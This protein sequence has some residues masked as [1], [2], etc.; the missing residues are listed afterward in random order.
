MLSPMTD[1]QAVNRMLKSIG[2]APVNTLEVSGIGDV[3]KARQE[4]EEV[5]RDVQTI[6][7]SWNTDDSYTL[8]PDTDGAIRLPNGALD[9]D[10]TE[11]TQ[12]IVVREHPSGGL[13]LY[14]A[15]NTTFTFTASVTVRVIWGF[16]FNSLPAAA[17][18]YIATAAARRF[19]AQV[20]SSTILDRF[21]ETD[22]QRAWVLLQ[23][24]ERATRD[25]NLFR[26]NS[27]VNKFG[28]RRRF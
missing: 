26:A 13:A 5:T 24:R 12:N 2:Q 20:V 10:S 4:L 23:R 17:R 28:S 6:G 18:V 8:S 9:V 7:W 27:S 22:E 3:N 1:L 21:N 25:T 15:D 11:T 16:E 19:Q 14:D